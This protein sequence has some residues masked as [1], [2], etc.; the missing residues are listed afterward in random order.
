MDDEDEFWS[1][2]SQDLNRL[3]A[4]LDPE[5]FSDA[6]CVLGVPGGSFHDQLGA[7]Q[8]QQISWGNQDSASTFDWAN[9]QAQTTNNVTSGGIY[10]PGYPLEYEPTY[11]HQS[12]QTSGFNQY[13]PSA[14]QQAY[15][16]TGYPVTSLQTQ[17]DPDL[18]GVATASEYHAGNDVT[19]PQVIYS[20]K[21]R[22]NET[23]TRRQPPAKKTKRSFR[24]RSSPSEPSSAAAEGGT[25]SKMGQKRAALGERMGNDRREKAPV[26]RDGQHLY[27]LVNGEWSM[28]V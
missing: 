20:P 11:I 14:F 27:G 21:S 16:P 12:G 28:S 17:Y 6:N 8:M 4:G 23:S 2:R 26:K 10:S 25:L 9:L 7:E 3:F 24:P 19:T 13:T 18:A 15:T 5:P 1:L 22:V